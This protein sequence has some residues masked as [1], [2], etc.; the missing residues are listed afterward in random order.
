[1]NGRYLYQV[2]DRVRYSEHQE[3]VGTIV[4][5]LTADDGCGEPIEKEDP[6][7]PYYRIDWDEDNFVGFE[8]EHLLVPEYVNIVPNLF[9]RDIH[10]NNRDLWETTVQGV[11]D[12]IENNKKD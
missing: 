11:F 5:L 6:S 2:G 9:I 1:M 4:S 3:T 10:E 7:N 8:H 12:W